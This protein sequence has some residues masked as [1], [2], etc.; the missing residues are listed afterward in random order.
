MRLFNFGIVFSAYRNFSTKG[1]SKPFFVPYGKYKSKDK[2]TSTT[3]KTERRLKIQWTEEQKSVLSSVSQGN[4]VFITGAAGTGKT[5]LV[6]EIVKLL[7]K[8]HTPS[9]V[10]VTASTGV[11]AILI[12]GQTLHSF[13][14]IRYHTDDPKILYDSIMSRKG[15]YWRWRKVKALVIDEIGMVDARLFDNLERVARKLRGVDET[16]GGIQLVVVGDFCQLPPIPDDDSVVKYA[17]EADCWNESFD[18]MIE[19]TKILRQSDPRFIELLQRIRMGESNPEDLSFLKSYCSKKKSDLSAVQ[20]FPRKKNVT[21]V[22]EE[23]LKSLQKSV[24]VYR[25]VDSGAKDRMRQLNQGIAP[26]EVS[27]CVGARVMLVKNMHIQEGLVNGATGTVVELVKSVNVNDVCP[28]NLLPIVKFDSG[29]VLKIKPE[30]WHVMDGDKIVATRKQIPLILAWALSIHKC[31]GMTLDKACINLSRAFGCG[32]VYTSLSR[33]RS[34]DGLHLSGFKAS[35]ILAD[36]KV[37]EFYRNFALQRNNKDQDNTR[38]KSTENSSS[39]SS[40]TCTSEKAGTTVKERHFSL[41]EYLA[42]RSL[43]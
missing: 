26:D 17:F 34:A 30:E 36:P 43:L 3:T 37:S 6:G 38:T 31:Q 10:F 13:A 29:K 33:I 15:A 21:K 22:N 35:K 8:L 40:I 41:Y 2:T 42:K 14:G 25:A 24:V 5:K 39:S 7:N 28:D 12:K 27:I 9:K 1:F 11:A 20:L 32:M 23:R 18:F 16:W 4:S 19:L